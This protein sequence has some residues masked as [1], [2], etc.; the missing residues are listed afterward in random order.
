MW[1]FSRILVEVDFF[2]GGFTSQ[3]SIGIKERERAVVLVWEQCFRL[4]ILQFILEINVI[5]YI[6][7]ILYS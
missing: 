3:T 4:S 2:V 7:Y 5:Q 6:S 1:F